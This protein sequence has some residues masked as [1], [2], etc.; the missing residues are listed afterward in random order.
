MSEK[1]TGRRRIGE[2]QRDESFCPVTAD[3]DLSVVTRLTLDILKKSSLRM[4]WDEFEE[5]IGLQ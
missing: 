4:R 3:R 2:L 5:T 1:N